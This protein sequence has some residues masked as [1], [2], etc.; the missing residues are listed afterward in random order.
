MNILKIEDLF[1]S[2]SLGRLDIPV[3][4][5]IN[6]AVD[7]GEFAAIM[8]PSGSGK[9]TLMNLIGCLDRPTSGKITIGGEDISLLAETDLARIRGERVG[10]VFQTFN[11]ISRLT[12]LK[13]VEL[14]MVYQDI[15][16]G[17]RLKRAAELLEMLG[18]T[19]RAD[20][21]PPEL[22]GGQRQRVAI[23]RALANEPDILLADEP[24]GNL[25]SK[26]GLEIM[27]IFNDLHSEGRTIIMVTHDRALAENCDR[28][29]RLKDG[30]IEDE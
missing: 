9:S 12:A 7:A 23:A 6:L 13:N 28:I 21:K 26:T 5:D 18:L 14:P 30:G 17:E 27:Q 25:D 11:L 24:T 10:F 1:K 22:S 20:H 29:I 2:Y 4:H 8:G 3:L 15:S 19:D 16:R